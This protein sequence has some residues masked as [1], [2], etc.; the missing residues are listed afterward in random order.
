MRVTNQSIA[1]STL[2]QLQSNLQAM[3]TARDQ[4]STGHRVN[5]MSDD[6]TAA[7]EVVRIGS[8]MRAIEQYRRNIRVA[9]GRAGEEEN[10]LDHLTDLLGRGIEL[11]IGQASSPSNAQTRTIAKAE[12]DQLIAGA[13]ELGNT[14]FGGD[15]L[16]GG[17]RGGEQPFRVPPTAADGFSALVDS[18]SNP[19]DPSGHIQIEIADGRFMQPTHNGTEVFLD[20]NALQ[21]LRD[22]ST[23]LGNND[24]AAINS[25]VQSLQQASDKVQTLIGTQGAR[26]AELQ[27][28]SDKL[29]SLELSMDKFRSNLRDIE[30][31]KAMLDLVGRQTM[32]QAAMAATT[33]IMGMSLVNYL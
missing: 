32:Y 4:V 8:S 13:V 23:A 27:D 16:F 33:R 9:T 12:V 3:D 10:A 31:E 7:S 1:Y 29:D 17:T 26:T 15:Y 11:A 18:G 30:V 19:V 20:S 28:A 24:T 22:L 2:S 14:K 25:A 6:P 5:K 21:S